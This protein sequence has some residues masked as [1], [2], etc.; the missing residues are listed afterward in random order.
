ME[1]SYEEEEEDEE[2]E[3]SVKRYYEKAIEL[4]DKGHK[5]VVAYESMAIGGLE[6]YVTLLKKG[7]VNDDKE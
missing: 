5:V 6:G 2:E 3:E 4:I 1:V 7:G